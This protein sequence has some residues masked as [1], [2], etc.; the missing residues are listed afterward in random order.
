M[1]GVDS[2]SLARA[3]D[4]VEGWLEYQHGNS[5]LPGLAVAIWHADRLLL[6]RGFGHADLDSRTPMKASHAFRIG[7]NSK[8]FTATAVYM[9][10]E[11]HA[12][13]LDDKVADHVPWFRSGRDEAVRHITIRQ[14]LCHGSGLAR[15]ADGGYWHPA[16]AFPAADAL[17]ELIAGAELVLPSGQQFKYSNLGYAI[18]G[19]V[20]EAAA[21]TSYTDFINA[22][23]LGPLGLKC[24]TTDLDPGSGTQLATGYLRDYFGHGRTPCPH[25]PMNALAPAGGFCSTAGDL[26]RFAAAQFLGAEAL[27]SD[28]A[29]R[30]MHQ[31]RWH[32]TQDSA[33]GSGFVTTTVRNRSLIGHVGE[34]SG[35]VSCTKIDPVDQLAVT[36]LTNSLDGPAAV[37]ANGIVA[38]IDFFAD[39][40][41]PASLRSGPQADLSRFE[42]RLFSAWNAVD[43]VAVAGWLLA[44]GPEQPR[45]FDDPTVLTA[46]TPDRLR[47]ARTS[48]YLSPGQEVSY[49]WRPEGGIDTVRFAGVPYYLWGDYLRR[50][51]S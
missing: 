8:M 30:D 16:G 24:T 13:R 49:T 38:I 4:Y 3:V 11:R 44:V 18:L 37:L 26:C 42:T 48:G 39:P 10:A 14:L 50:G 31:V 51:R 17:R 27:L 5:G 15:D 40:R 9:L 43:I 25:L 41:L 20:V 34:Y 1:P 36:V 6:A 32:V 23:I 19:L 22:E 45:P 2:T 33:Y 35:F 12:L 28:A 7:S 21:G 47:I 29:K 46:E